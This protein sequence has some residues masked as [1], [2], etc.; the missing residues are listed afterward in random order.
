M[1]RIHAAVNRKRVKVYTVGHSSEDWETF[2]NKLKYHKIQLLVD[3][4]SLPGSRKFPWFN[5]E[6][7]EE[8]LPIPYHHMPELG[9]R[10]KNQKAGNIN[11]GWENL[12]FRNYA[13]YMQTDDFKSGLQLLYRMATKSRVTIMCA[14]SC[15]WRCHRRII[16]DQLVHSGV[17]VYDIIGDK[18]KKHE[19]SSFACCD[20][21]ILRYPG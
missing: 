12:S 20:R 2:V 10:R 4:R 5:Q 7:F 19:I 6:Y 17:R 14:E 13:D 3:V 1:A 15:W 21:K 11:N 9:G 8:H 18:K 16:A